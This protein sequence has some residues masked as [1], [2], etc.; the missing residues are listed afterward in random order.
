MEPVERGYLG[1]CCGSVFGVVETCRLSF[2]C[3]HCLLMD[4]SSGGGSSSGSSRLYVGYM[5]GRKKKEMKKG[6]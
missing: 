2:H 3:C 4:G 6:F 1:G 5:R